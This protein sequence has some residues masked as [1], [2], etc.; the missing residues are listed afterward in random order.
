[1]ICSE[2]NRGRN[3]ILTILFRLKSLNIQSLQMG[4]AYQ[5]RVTAGNLYGF[6]TPSEPVN[7]SLDEIDKA[8]KVSQ[9]QEAPTRGKK[10]KVDD[11]DKFCKWNKAM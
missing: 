6:G 7:V 11:Y 1:M 9:H 3:K 8:R 5:L 10:V 2:K 4:H